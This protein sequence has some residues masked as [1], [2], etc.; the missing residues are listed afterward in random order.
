MSRVPTDEVDGLARADFAAA[1][2]R[3]T[4]APVVVVIP[5]YGEADNIGPVLAR[6]PPTTN[7]VAVSVLVV[8]DGLQNGDT[9]ADQA[10][11]VG[12]FAAVAPV[13]RGQGAAL[14][15]GYALAREHGATCIV[16][17]DADG[18]YDP[19]ELDR[20]TEP[21]LAGRADLVNG[22]RRLGSATGED[23]VRSLGVT[24]FGRIIGA[25]GRTRIT[26]PASGFRAM[27]ADLTAQV[28]LREPQYQAAE[29][30]LGALRRGARVLEVPVS[31]RPR[32]SGQSK[33]AANLIYGAQFA[34]VVAG[35]WLR[36]R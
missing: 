35:T 24:V 36:S 33:K 27:T 12:A 10:R 15:L 4:F 5:C 1:H 28:P 7:G 22:S 3:P 29:L 20:L 17:L 25:L 16:T 6:I 14:R 30:L 11:S 8:I 34:R 2:G 32:T 31:R 23:P 9:T 18:Q 21:V 26:D 13:N 19:A